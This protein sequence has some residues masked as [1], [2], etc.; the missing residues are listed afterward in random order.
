MTLEF[1]CVIFKQNKIFKLQEYGVGSPQEDVEI[2]Q[3]LVSLQEELRKL[4]EA[5]RLLSDALSRQY[6]ASQ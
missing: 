4:Q 1:C 5:E 6:L 3:K 2:Y